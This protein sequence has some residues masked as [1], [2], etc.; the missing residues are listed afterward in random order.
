MNM[1]SLGDYAALQ[2]EGG[3]YYQAGG[4]PN[5]GYV[6]DQNFDEEWH[7]VFYVFDWGRNNHRVYL[8]VNLRLKKT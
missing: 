8:I 4:R 2:N 5:V 1:V 7:Q 6:V 3:L